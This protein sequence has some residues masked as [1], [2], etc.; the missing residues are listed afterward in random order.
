M[1]FE[2]EEID[3]QKKLFTKK[4]TYK[5]KVIGVVEQVTTLFN[6]WLKKGLEM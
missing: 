5:I 4:S 6:E 3:R 1:P 2:I